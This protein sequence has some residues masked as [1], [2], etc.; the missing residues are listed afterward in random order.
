MM[1]SAAS[2]DASKIPEKIDL[3]IFLKLR[4]LIHLP[5]DNHVIL[6]QQTFDQRKVYCVI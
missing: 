6:D 4:D 1:G 5:Q 3:P 2:V